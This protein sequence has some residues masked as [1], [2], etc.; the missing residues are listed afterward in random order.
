MQNVFLDLL[1]FV[2]HFAVNKYYDPLL[3][4]MFSSTG[5]SPWDVAEELLEVCSGG[6]GNTV[7]RLVS[8]ELRAVE[9]EC[10][11]QVVSL[12]DQIT[13]SPPGTSNENSSPVRF[14]NNDLSTS[15]YCKQI[16]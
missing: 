11:L 9:L 15:R 8:S 7:A 16:C 2:P 12:A 10:G 6:P 5:Q 3:L 13:Y 1:G 4:Q 14:V